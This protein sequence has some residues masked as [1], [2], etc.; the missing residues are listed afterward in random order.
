[1]YP[2]RPPLFQAPEEDTKY[3]LRR[4]NKLRWDAGARKHCSEPGIGTSRQFFYKPPE[5][6]SRIVSCVTVVQIYGHVLGD[7]HLESEPLQCVLTRHLY[8]PFCGWASS[9]SSRILR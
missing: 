8:S 2:H 5:R 4:S 6:A 7:D 3:R 1:M 9:A